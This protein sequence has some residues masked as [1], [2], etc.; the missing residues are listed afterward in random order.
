MNPAAGFD[1]YM[2][3]DLMHMVVE[4]K[5]GLNRAVFGQLAAGGLAGTFRIDAVGNLSKRDTARLLR[6]SDK[7][8][9]SLLR[10]GRDDSAASERAT[11]ICWFEW[12]SRSSDKSLKK[13]A[14]AMA[15]NAKHVRD[16]APEAEL[17]ALGRDTLDRI[18]MHLDEL[19]SRW[20]GLA[21]GESMTV[22]WPDLTLL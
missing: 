18:C 17:E 1:N 14:A 10:E 7:R 12:L 11:Y 5:L 3:H 21:P 22:S 2:P 13:T 19:S 15:S 4:A 9:E 20:S 16:T 6:R 8:D